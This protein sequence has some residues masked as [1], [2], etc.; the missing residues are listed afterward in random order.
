MW[1]Q[2]FYPVIIIKLQKSSLFVLS[3][4]AATGSPVLESASSSSS[5]FGLSLQ[6]GLA[7]EYYLP[8]NHAV[9][10][11][12]F[13]RTNLSHILLHHIQKSSPW[14]PTLLPSRQ[15]HFHH[16]SS[17][18]FLVSPH[19]MSIPPQPALSHFHS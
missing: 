12:H 18:I 19:D 2:L 15:L 9:F 6:S 4:V 10:N 14:S 8:P 13:L 1:Y 17:Y 16:P 7:T 3:C 11:V 5:P